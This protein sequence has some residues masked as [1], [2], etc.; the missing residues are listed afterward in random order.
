MFLIWAPKADVIAGTGWNQ[1]NMVLLAYNMLAH[2]SFVNLSSLAKTYG[3]PLLLI[4][5]G[6][7]YGGPLF[8]AAWVL[9]GVALIVWYHQSSLPL[10]L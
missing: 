4:P 7:Y 6:T 3:P 1:W 10:W 5:L 8:L 9:V 2:G